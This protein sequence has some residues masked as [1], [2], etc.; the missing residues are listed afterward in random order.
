MT[1]PE[2]TVLVNSFIIYVA[3]YELSASVVNLFLKK[4]KAEYQEYSSKIQDAITNNQ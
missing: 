2:I 1:S 3:L 4:D